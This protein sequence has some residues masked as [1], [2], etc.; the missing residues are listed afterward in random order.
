MAEIV[1]FRRTREQPTGADHVALRMLL[2]YMSQVL[3]IPYRALFEHGPD[4]QE[5]AIK[6]YV[7][8]KSI[9]GRPSAIAV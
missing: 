7:N 5:D 8:D 4:L 1:P 9:Q 2:K 3:N 6:S